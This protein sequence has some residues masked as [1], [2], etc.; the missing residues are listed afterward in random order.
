VLAKAAAKAST[1]AKFLVREAVEQRLNVCR[2]LL[3]AN[4]FKR[5]YIKRR[6]KHQFSRFEVLYS[7]LDLREV[8]HR[9]AILRRKRLKGTL[10]GS[11][12]VL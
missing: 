10:A 8:A 6:A 4:S 3:G 5:F 9:R 2:V 12:E 1:R 7:A 11:P